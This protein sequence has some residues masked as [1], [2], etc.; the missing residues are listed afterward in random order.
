MDFYSFTK[1]CKGGV[2]HLRAAF[3]QP[4]KDVVK[5]P[6]AF[7]HASL[8]PLQGLER[9]NF[10][11]SAP[12]LRSLFYSAFAR[13]KEAELGASISRLQGLQTL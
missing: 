2:L 5:D 10:G 6:R 9:R 7:L 12:R 8:Q 3:L 1:A 11:E 4:V 13:L